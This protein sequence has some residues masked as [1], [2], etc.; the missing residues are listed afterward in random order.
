MDDITKVK[1]VLLALTAIEGVEAYLGFSHE[2]Q[3]VVKKGDVD[4]I[5]SES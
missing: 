5:K 2:Y 1:G 4:H 3:V